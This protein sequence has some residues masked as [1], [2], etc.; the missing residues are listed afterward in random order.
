MSITFFAHHG[1]PYVQRVAIVLAEKG[2]PHLRRDIDF[3]QKPADFLAASPLGQVPAL[4]VEGGSLFDSLAICEYLDDHYVPRIHPEDFA[5]RGHHRA[6]MAFGNAL[7]QSIGGFFK[8]RDQDAFVACRKEIVDRLAM[9]ERE[10]TRAPYFDGASF[11]MVDV[12]FAPIFR[13]FDAFSRME[14]FDFFAGLTRVPAWRRELAQ[15]PSV[16][17]AV[18]PDFVPKLVAYLQARGSVFSRH[19]AKQS[20]DD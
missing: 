18:D 19:A 2:I 11:S 7:L 14:R 12:V 1:C 6:W 9:L 8:A 15:R 3:R 16:A 10:L 4:L 20:G 13:Y 5:R 17:G